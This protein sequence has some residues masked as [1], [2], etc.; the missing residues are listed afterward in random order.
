MFLK[1]DQSL[2]VYIS[3]AINLRY[4]EIVLSHDLQIQHNNVHVFIDKH[5][6]HNYWVQGGGYQHRLWEVI[7]L[8]GVTRCYN[9]LSWPSFLFTEKPILDSASMI[10]YIIKN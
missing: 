3:W 7:L 6:L 5:N 4:W 9:F 2:H 10:V 1:Y 8:F